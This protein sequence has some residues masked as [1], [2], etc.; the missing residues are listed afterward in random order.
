MRGVT[1]NLI[2]S[3][4]TQK[5]QRSELPEALSPEAAQLGEPLEA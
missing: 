1:A 4:L 2:S 3:H 5:V